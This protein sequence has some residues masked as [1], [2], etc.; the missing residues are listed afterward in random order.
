VN[1]ELAERHADA[2]LGTLGHSG[3]MISFSK[4]AFRRAYPEN[5]AVFNANVCLT[6]GK[7]WHGD[8]DL[9]VGESTLAALAERIGE[10]V[11]VLFERDG[12]FEHEDHPRLDEAVFSV[13]S[14]GHT[15]YQHVWIER[16]PD[17]TLRRRPPP[18]ETRRRLV[19]SVGSPRLWRFWRVERVSQTE[20]GLNP[21]RSTLVYVGQRRTQRR[22]PLLVLGFFRAPKPRRWLGLEATW[23]PSRKR[24]APRPLLSG[25]LRRRRGRLRPYVR[26]YVHPG[27]MYEL[28]FGVVG[29]PWL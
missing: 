26:V 27:F 16:A 18:P 3:R 23:Y 7:V 10:T 13:T 20:R 11:Y 5:V 22:S 21:V 28:A 2:L 19:L 15:R 6:A 14:S 25:S 1:E 24:H 17:G 12:R 9:T 4:S 29:R 8:V